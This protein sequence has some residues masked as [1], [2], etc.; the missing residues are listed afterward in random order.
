MKTILIAGG[1]G[2]I[3]TNLSRH[4][5]EA[6]HTVYILS[7]KPKRKNQ[8]YWNAHEKKIEGKHLEKIEIIINLAGAGI[9][10]KRWTNERKNEILKSRTDTIDYLFISATNFPKLEHFITVSGID[11]FGFNNSSKTYSET[12]DYGT[13]F[14][15]DVVRQWEEKAHLFDT[16]YKTTILR[17]P[18]VLDSEKGALPKMASPIKKYLGSPIG[19]GKQ[20][21]NWVH[22]D[23][24]IAVFNH[25]MTHSIQ[26][27]FNIVGGNNTNEDFTKTLAQTLQKPLFLPNVP[28][29]VMKLILGEMAILLLN[30]NFI[31]G[32]KLIDTGFTYQH[33]ELEETLKSIYDN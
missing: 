32:K 13:D 9:A 16:K 20:N 21:M 29:F 25:V 15:S 5:Q 27:T 30:G 26:G 4:F 7:R 22:I 31:S 6:G 2:F 18:I 28:S 8:I 3:G 23:D 33:T 11:C 12:D 10:D 19:S 24:L 17:L 14:L 1:T